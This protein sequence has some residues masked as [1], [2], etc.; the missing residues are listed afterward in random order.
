[1][2]LRKR[3]HR[4]RGASLP[5]TAIIMSAL[6]LVL[7]GI[8][9]FGRAMYTY[10]FV[11][12]IAREGARWAMVRGSQCTVLNDC[13]NVSSAQVQS[14]VQ[15]LSEGPTTASQISATATWPPSECVPGSTGEAP[16]CVVQVVV[17]YPFKFMVIP[18]LLSTQINMS[19]TSQM[20]VS[21]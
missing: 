1:M 13:P 10:A 19:S 6:L 21:Q 7:F 3:S 17:T 20:V 11:A 5:E 8:I 16:G 18:F 14:Y 12:Q 9:D 2:R 15:S 4:E